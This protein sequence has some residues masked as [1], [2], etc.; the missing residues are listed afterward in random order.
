M[1]PRKLRVLQAHIKTYKIHD[2]CQNLRQDFDIYRNIDHQKAKKLKKKRRGKNKTHKQARKQ[3]NKR[4]DKKTNRQCRLFFW[5]DAMAGAIAC[6]QT[7][8]TKRQQAT[9]HANQHWTLHV[10]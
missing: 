2:V 10:E 7:K 6:G 5:S 8:Q 4:T 1:T 9:K 3:I